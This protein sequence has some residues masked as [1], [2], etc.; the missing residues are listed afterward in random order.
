MEDEVLTQYAI[1]KQI[2]TIEYI[3]TNYGDI[4]LN[5]DEI[6]KLRIFLKELLK[7]RLTN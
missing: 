7:Q 5:E 6:E 2:N 1:N 4:Y 3:S